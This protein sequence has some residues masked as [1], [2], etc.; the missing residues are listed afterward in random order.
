MTLMIYCAMN[1][2][3]GQWLKDRAT[4]QG[5]SGTQAV[6]FTDFSCTKS[7]WMGILQMDG[8]SSH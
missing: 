2:G 7:V 6:T 5:R 4:R 8:R 1:F 3:V